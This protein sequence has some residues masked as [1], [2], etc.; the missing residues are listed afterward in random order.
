MKLLYEARAN[1]RA[2]S[3]VTRSSAL[4]LA[5]ENHAALEVVELLLAWRASTDA[6]D[7][8]GNTALALACSG[9]N[10][11]VVLALLATNARVN[12]QNTDTSSALNGATAM[13]LACYNGYA[14]LVKPLFEAK[15]DLTI[16]DENG[17]TALHFACYKGYAD[18]LQA[19]LDCNDDVNVQTKR[20]R[21]PLHHAATN[22]HLS[23][24]QLLLSAK[25]DLQ[26]LDV[27]NKATALHGACDRGHVDVVRVLVEERAHV[28]VRDN[29]G[30]TPFS[31]ACKAG[32]EVVANF[33]R[34]HDS[35][36]KFFKIL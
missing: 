1:P 30:D 12:M 20:G 31:L 18:V 10:T 28:H 33:L 22:G 15:A 21:S 17:A 3:S 25:A 29:N 6:V 19:L 34:Q 26:C 8:V 14:K 23:T 32:R 7:S 9:G 35:A 11:D 36:N 16:R 4:H 24:V 27:V 13:H 2:F 5:A